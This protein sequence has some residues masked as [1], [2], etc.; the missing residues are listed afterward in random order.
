[1]SEPQANQ[2]EPTPDASGADTWTQAQV[3]EVLKTVFDPELHINIV[4]LGLV[5]GIQI[6]GD[7][8]RIQMTL[9]SPGC[10]YAPYLLHLTKD[11]L[12]NLKGIRD[13]E[14]E[15]VWEPPWGPDKMS[16]ETR[17]ELGFDI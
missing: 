5:Y 4:D 3:R 14:I 16:E 6:E 15:V 1:M 10:P 12:V 7:L 2:P 17:L 11:T 8:I 13:A 9:T